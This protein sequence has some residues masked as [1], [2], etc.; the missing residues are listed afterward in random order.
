MPRNATAFQRNLMRSFYRVHGGDGDQVCQAFS[1]AENE[2]RFFRKVGDQ[3]LSPDDYARALFSDGIDRGWLIRDG[4]TDRPD[5]PF[6]TK[7]NDDREHSAR[8]P[9]GSATPLL[10]CGNLELRYAACR[11]GQVRVG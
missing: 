11:N 7:E 10:P 8:L 4:G 1:R 2:C 5:R 3:R 9:I 6:A